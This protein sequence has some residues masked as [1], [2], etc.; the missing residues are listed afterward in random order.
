VKS[1]P[2][3][4]SVDLPMVP[5]FLLQIWCFVFLFGGGWRMEEKRVKGLRE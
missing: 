1:V 5:N 3:P 2:K 4:H